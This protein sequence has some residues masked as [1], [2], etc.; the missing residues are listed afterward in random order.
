MTKVRESPTQTASHDELIS[1]DVDCC[2]SCEEL[3][4]GIKSR[5]RQAGELPGATVDQ[6]TSLL[7]EL[8]SLELGRFLLESRRY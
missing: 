6:Q 2:N 4:Q 1:H 3:L 5:L 7:E 8:Y